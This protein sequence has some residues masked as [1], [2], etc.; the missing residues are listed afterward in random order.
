M[1]V[2]IKQYFFI[3]INA[4]NST[5]SSSSSSSSIVLVVLVVVGQTVGSIW[6]IDKCLFIPSNISQNIFQLKLYSIYFMNRTE[7]WAHIL[8]VQIILL[9]NVCHSY[10]NYFFIRQSHLYSLFFITYKAI[11]S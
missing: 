5:S 2:K 3:Y 11:A 7:I 8:C 9:H 1:I 4:L 6:S 10:I